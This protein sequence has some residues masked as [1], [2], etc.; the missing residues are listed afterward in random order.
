VTKSDDLSEE[1]VSWLVANRSRNQ[2][3][4]LKLFLILKHGSEEMK[5]RTDLLDASQGLVA[6]CFSLWRAVF[7]SDI[8]ENVDS[9]MA[10]DVE[11]FLG[12]LILHNTVLQS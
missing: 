6:A 10:G 7:L 5:G 4:S 8:S 3:A 9:T 12:N 11:A 2:A 1:H